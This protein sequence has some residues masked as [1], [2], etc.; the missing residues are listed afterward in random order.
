MS[1]RLLP[2]M[3]NYVDEVA[4]SGSIQGAARVL[5]ISASAIDRQILMLEDELGA[6]LFERQAG[7]MRLSPAGELMVALARRW[8]RDAHRV[9]SEIEQLKG[10][11]QGFLHLAAMD[12]HANGFLPSFVERL[13]REHPRVRVEIDIVSTDQAERALTD[14]EADFVAAFNLKAS[15]EIHLVWSADL[16]LGCIVAPGHPLAS[17]E[18]LTLKQAA[19]Y[20]LALQSRALMIRRYLESR[21]GWLFS[22]GEPPVATN[23]LQLLKRLVSAGTHVA[24]TSE[25]DAAPEILD[26]RLK[27]IPL[28]GRDLSAQ[29]VAVAVSARRPLS[30]IARIVADILAEEVQASLDAVRAFRALPPQ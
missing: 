8:R 3:L 30:R 22:D 18:S 12:S 7:G 17:S 19:A 5:S 24:F 14:G 1:L 29:T 11:H 10:V 20:P 16:P 9:A 26:G 13:T 2:R 21:H 15:R 28:Q 27:F 4:R 6:P 23:S 25:L